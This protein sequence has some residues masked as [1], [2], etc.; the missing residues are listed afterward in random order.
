MARS[1]KGAVSGQCPLPSYQLCQGNRA[2]VRIGNE[3]FV[4][5]KQFERGRRSPE[6]AR[7]N[8]ESGTP[9]AGDRRVGLE[10]HFGDEIAASSKDTRHGFNERRV[11]V[12]NQ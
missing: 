6:F 3:T 9:G 11:G 2:A 8:P 4:V 12:A 7:R 1:G 10:V 5:V